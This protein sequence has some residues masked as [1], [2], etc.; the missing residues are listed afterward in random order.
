MGSYPARIPPR[1]GAPGSTTAVPPGSFAG[2]QPAFPD[3]DTVKIL[4]S[5][6]DAILA[7]DLDL[8]VL[9]DAIT[10]A[11][12]RL[13]SADGVALALRRNG[14]V[15]C[16]SRSGDPAPELGARLHVDSGISG[17]C[18]RTGRTLRCDDTE[19]DWR[20]DPEVCRRLGLR[21]IAVVPL[22]GRHG[23]MGV[24][25]AFSRRPC[26]FAEEHIATLEQLADLAEE[27]RARRSQ[28]QA[29]AEAQPQAAAS[30]RSAAAAW[31]R[32]QWPKMHS[33]VT[34]GSLAAL[35]I[36]SL[37]WLT[38]R[39][40]AASPTPVAQAASSSIPGRSAVASGA[41]PAWKP[42]AGREKNLGSASASSAVQFAASLEGEPAQPPQ[43]PL[44]QGKPALGSV[45]LAPVSILSSPPQ[46]AVPGKLLYRVQPVYPR[47]ALAER[48]EGPVVLQGVIAEDG[49]VRDL[50]AVSGEPLLAQS[51]INSLSQWIYQ[52]YRQDGK[53][54]SVPT[55]ITVSFKLP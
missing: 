13:T 10:D 28:P 34:L 32:S 38:L 50:K 24:L 40:P 52:P 2:I 12:R 39:R 6:K 23:A 49:R 35:L 8:L 18:L 55:E 4:A 53:P 22:R 25:E 5:L 36:L 33:R 41:A 7:N 46:G 44:S 15:V 43:S 30:R 19:R 21:S 42:S 51:A 1:P 54:V 14:V 45:L 31:L 3:P 27:A 9:L 26:A 20:A 37:G 17:E 47:E 29:A 48:L 16:R 11:A